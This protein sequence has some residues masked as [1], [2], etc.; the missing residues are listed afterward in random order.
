M[1]LLPGDDNSDDGADLSLASPR[2]LLSLGCMGSHNKRLV[3]L[4]GTRRGH[5]DKLGAVESK[6]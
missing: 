3:D 5:F 1:K 2:W 4:C 6:S